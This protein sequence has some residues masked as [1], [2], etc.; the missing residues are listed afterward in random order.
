MIC[1][2]IPIDLTA[3]Q[4][5]QI[6]GILSV[7]CDWQTAANFVG[8]SLADIRRTMQQEPQFAASLLRAEAGV[9]LS[10]MRNIQQAAQETKNWRTSVWWLERH[11]PERFGRRG[12]GIITARQIKAFIDVLADILRDDVKSD[13]DRQQV[14]R[15]LESLANSVDRM[16]RDNGMDETGS[17]ETGD[18]EIGELAEEQS[19]DVSFDD[20]D[21]ADETSS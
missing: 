16:L 6:C 18:P 20:F 5:G 21:D 4:K 13:H 9:E 10:H 12:A 14:L 8:C 1:S 17:T 3:E 15:R 19:I 11:S 2:L 7:G